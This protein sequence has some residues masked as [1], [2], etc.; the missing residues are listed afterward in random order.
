VAFSI[1]AIGGSY[2]FGEWWYGYFWDG[3][4]R[5]AEYISDGLA[6]LLDQ[7]PRIVLWVSIAFVIA[8]VAGWLLRR[9]LFWSADRFG[10]LVILCAVVATAADAVVLRRTESEAYWAAANLNSSLNDAFKDFY[11]QMQEV[12]SPPKVEPPIYF[13]YLD[14]SRVE[15]LYNE[16][17]P[18]LVVSQ[19]EET[20]SSTVKG[21]AEAGVNGAS[22]GVEAGKNRG[23]KSVFAPADFS[24]DRKCLEVMKH[25]QDKWPAKYYS[26][27]TDWYA[28]K[29][30]A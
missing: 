22:V 1:Y 19:H 26:N 10:W 20:G 21:K 2:L 14:A 30:F 18:D 16:L 27:E 7:Y 23:T 24:S 13:H 8:I 9:W 3:G 6:V 25:V 12:I 4:Y 15:A 29:V 11:D 17:L 28:R 5:K